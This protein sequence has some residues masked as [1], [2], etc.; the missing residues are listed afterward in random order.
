MYT[1]MFVYT[2]ISITFQMEEEGKEE[3]TGSVL[4]SQLRMAVWG[5]NEVKSALTAVYP[6]SHWGS[7]SL[8]W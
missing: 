4:S 5:S 7:M 8:S 3:M 6:G 1:S 2:P